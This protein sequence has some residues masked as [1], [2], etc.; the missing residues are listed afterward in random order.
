MNIN[1]QNQTG[2][3]LEQM[4]RG[5]DRQEFYAGV[6]TRSRIA[7]IYD[8]YYPH[9]ISKLPLNEDQVIRTLLVYS[10]R[11]INMSV[12]H[13]D[14]LLING[15]TDIARLDLDRPEKDLVI[16]LVQE[17]RE[18]N[19]IDTISRIVS[20]I[21]NKLP[22]DLQERYTPYLKTVTIQKLLTILGA[23]V[24]VGNR[25]SSVFGERLVP[26][27]KDREAF[28]NIMS[29]R[30]DANT[31]PK[32]TKSSL[33]NNYL[34]DLDKVLGKDTVAALQKQGYDLK[35]ISRERVKM[36]INKGTYEQ[37]L[38][39]V[40]SSGNT[41]DRVTKDV[42]PQNVLFGK[43]VDTE[44]EIQMDAKTK[45]LYYFDD[46]SRTLIPLKDVEKINADIISKRKLE[47]ML[48]NYELS[49]N[50]LAAIVIDPSKINGDNGSNRKYN[51]KGEVINTNKLTPQQRERLNLSADNFDGLDGWYIYLIIFVVIM[52]LVIGGYFGYRWYSKRQAIGQQQPANNTVKSTT[53]VNNDTRLVRTKNM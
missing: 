39:A 34:D 6:L 17:N 9:L 21:N 11:Y 14:V 26:V 50:E 47:A 49:N 45:E 27:I 16:Q 36:N 38:S 7:T 44:P 22:M 30:L 5:I 52:V 51:A 28:Q 29:N 53:I 46:T 48:K 19:D 40:L 25:E 35:D 2:A 20:Q 15:L 41:S 4:I 13:V 37:Q 31:T 3:A 10:L 43:Y 1:P 32:P 23:E 42:L 33:D 18:I 24:L 8:K 12:Q